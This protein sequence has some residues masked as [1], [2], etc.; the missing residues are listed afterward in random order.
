MRGLR[1]PLAT[2]AIPRRQAP[3]G[4]RPRRSASLGKR[5]LKAAR[6]LIASG[7]TA[8]AGDGAWCWPRASRAL[9]A[10]EGDAS[11]GA[12]GVERV[13]TEKFDDW[14][15]GLPEDHKQWVSACGFKAKS[16]EICMMPSKE[17]GISKVVLG[18]ETA[19]DLCSYAALATGLPSGNYAI[20]GAHDQ[21]DMDR[22]AMGWAMGTYTF[23][24]YKKPEED[25]QQAKLCWPKGC[26]KSCVTSLVEALYLIRDMI[27]TPAEDLGPE[28]IAAEAMAVAARHGA[29][30]DVIVGEDLL[31]SNYPAIH[32]VG[33]ASSRAPRLVDIRWSADPNKGDLPK[34]ALV[35]KGVA[36]DTG[37]LDIKTAQGMKGMKKD[38]GGAAHVLG[39]AHVIMANRLPVSLRVLVPTVE[40][41][42]SGNAYRPSDVLQTRS[43]I[44]VENGN[45]DAEGRLI[46]CD[47]M[48]EAAQDEPDLMI[49]MATLTGAARVALGP[50]LPAMFSSDD[51]VAEAILRAGVAE[52]DPLW[53]MPLH[54]PYRKMLDSKVADTG[55]CSEGPLGGAITAALFLQKFVKDVPRWV[56]IDTNA[57]NPAGHTKPGKPEGGEAQA[58]RALWAFLRDR[59]AA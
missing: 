6:R 21:A 51:G 24:R 18:M 22:V 11:G 2:P 33:R 55:S 50:S 3:L 16:G 4:A 25:K 52:D 28:E 38:M 10:Y 14:R 43:G 40:N 12:I 48:F 29:K 15:K 44:T 13:E 34:V 46:L 30:V 5:S 54:S 35:G 32:T 49:D 56:H 53:R 1:A 57:S 59:Y 27:N 26:D 8:M 23:E 58:L 45:T 31:T 42:I 20:E 47:A 39:L 9:D 19:S 36:F 41:S 7:A 37:G 17:G